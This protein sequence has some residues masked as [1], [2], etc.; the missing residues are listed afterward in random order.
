MP[1]RST[2]PQRNPQEE[3]RF[4]DL[5]NTACPKFGCAPLKADPKLTETAPAQ[6]LA[7]NPNLTA[8]VAS[9]YPL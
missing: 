6:D 1:G 5:I 9:G 8:A 3:Q 2:P 4:L 7:G